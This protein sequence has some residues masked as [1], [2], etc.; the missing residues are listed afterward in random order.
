MIESYLAH[1]TS[2]TNYTVP[3]VVVLQAIA[4]HSGPH[5]CIL[6]FENKI[7][8]NKKCLWAILE[9]V[10]LTHSIQLQHIACHSLS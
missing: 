10:Y 4:R 8:F 2:I 6:L 3:F 1:Y 9:P 5:D 7:Y